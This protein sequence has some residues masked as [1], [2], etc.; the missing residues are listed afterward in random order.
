MSPSEEV[1][2]PPPSQKTHTQTRLWSVCVCVW[3][4][5]SKQ[6]SEHAP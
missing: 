3:V 5:E 1:K 4:V 2:S 6:E